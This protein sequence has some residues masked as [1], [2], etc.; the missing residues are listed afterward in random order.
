MYPTA[1]SKSGSAPSLSLPSQGI[2]LASTYKRRPPG[3]L[4]RWAWAIFLYAF[5]AP[6]A[7]ILHKLGRTD[8]LFKSMMARRNLRMKDV[9][10]FKGYVPTRHDIFVATFADRKSTRLN[11]SHLGISYSV[12]CLN[13]KRN[14]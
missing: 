9:N 10:P 3:W 12:L 11:S 4:W 1:V 7:R 14:K 8:R 2:E 6:F 5:L 13:K